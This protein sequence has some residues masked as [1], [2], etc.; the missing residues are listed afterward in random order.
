MP[1]KREVRN[2]DGEIIDLEKDD[3]LEKLTYETASL[4]RRVGS[5]LFDFMLMVVIWY[6]FIE[7]VFE[8][9]GPIDSFIKSLGQDE[10]DFENLILFNEF[11]DLVWKLFLNLWLAWL[12][13]NTAYYTLVPALIGDGRTVGKMIAGIGVVSHQTLEEVSP[14]R[15]VLREFVGKVLIEMLFI[16]PMI[17]S[18]F[19]A[20]AREDSRMIHD[21]VSKTV[22]I[23]FDLYRLDEV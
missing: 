12:I 13:V 6:I 16:I 4:A 11:K 23:K 19:M 8:F 22:V 18:V 17:V 15:L 2:I 21:I 5:Y 1:E 10:R 9:M 3:L 14:S 20:L 7:Y